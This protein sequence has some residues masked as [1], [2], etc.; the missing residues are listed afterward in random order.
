MQTS[1]SRKMFLMQIFQFYGFMKSFEEVMKVQAAKWRDFFGA[2]GCIE[3]PELANKYRD[4]LYEQKCNDPHRLYQMFV[5]T[6]QA[7][8]NIHQEYF[9]N[10]DIRA[11]C[12]YCENI[13]V[14]MIPMLNGESGEITNRSFRCSCE[15]GKIKFGGVPEASPS[16][17]AWRLKENRR[18]NQKAREYI[19]GIGLDPDKPVSFR[20]FFNHITR[21]SGLIGKNVV[22]SK[23]DSFTPPVRIPDEEIVASW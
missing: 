22:A 17:L 21:R 15:T 7:N 14:V 10:I 20:E 3:H 16:S 18:E 8:R 11:N 12:E 6:V 13:G 4:K 5:A 9:S 19:Q 1:E 2:S 23:K